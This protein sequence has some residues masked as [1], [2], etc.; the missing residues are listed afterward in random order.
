MKKTIFTFLLL[1]TI[2]ASAQEVMS[3]KGNRL[4]SYPNVTTIN[5]AVQEYVNQ[6]CIT[7]LESNIRYMQDLGVRNATSEIALQTQNW[8]IEQFESYGGL[9]IS[10]HYFP[11]KELSA[12]RIAKP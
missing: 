11:Y 6:V 5:S 2:T 1:S 7:N 12:H 10:V 3:N 9:D 4:Q 8:L